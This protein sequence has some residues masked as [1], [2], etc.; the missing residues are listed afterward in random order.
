[1]SAL[2]AQPRYKGRDLVRWTMFSIRLKDLQAIKDRA[3]IVDTAVRLEQ[4]WEDQLG[5][6][7]T[8]NRSMTCKGW[9]LCKDS[10]AK[11]CVLREDR[12]SPPLWYLGATYGSY[13]NM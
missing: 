1:M 12:G 11:L 5:S 8:W 7:G 4:R 3:G 10:K 9:R 6:R 2:Q 13:N